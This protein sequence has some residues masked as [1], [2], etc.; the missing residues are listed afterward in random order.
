[1]GTKSERNAAAEPQTEARRSCGTVRLA[2]RNERAV[3][4]QWNGRGREAYERPAARETK[5]SARWSRRFRVAIPNRMS[6]R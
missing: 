1:M 4:A 3:F 2:V 6:I 5:Q